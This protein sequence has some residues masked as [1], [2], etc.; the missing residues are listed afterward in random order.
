VRRIT[1]TEGVLL[2]APY[3]LLSKAARALR[4][5]GETGEHN[6]TNCP[7]EAC[8]G[9]VFSVAVGDSDEGTVV[10]GGDQDR[11]R[12]AGS[13]GGAGRCCYP[14]SFAARAQ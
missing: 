13:G 14:D 8:I 2:R 6:G 12:E 5:S 1:S 7:V 4:N 9:R 11:R 10:C 3:E